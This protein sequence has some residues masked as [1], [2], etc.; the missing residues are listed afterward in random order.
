MPGRYSKQEKSKG[1]LAANEVT[2][3][4]TVPVMEQVRPDYE[5]AVRMLEEGQYEP[6]VALMRK[7]SE[8]APGL[9]AAHLALGIAYA[10]TGDLERAEASLNKALEQNPHPAAY[11][12]LGMLQRR[13]KDFAKARASYEAALAQSADFQ[14]AHRNLGILCDL[15]LG[16]TKRALEHYEAYGRIVPD[17]AEVV[18]WIADL[19][20]RESKKEKP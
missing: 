13:N 7:V 12:E 16:D 5:A 2:D 14:H 17:D 6:G 20:N 3:A 4:A 8:Q 11:N 19:R 15:Y 18:K 10:R 1:F 9:T